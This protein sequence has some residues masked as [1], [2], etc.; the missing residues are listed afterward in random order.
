VFRMHQ[1]MKGANH[2][3]DRA[4]QRY[5]RYLRSANFSCTLH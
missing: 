5:A 4:A 2:L 3:S 1:T